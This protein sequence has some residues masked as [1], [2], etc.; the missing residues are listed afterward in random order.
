MVQ[1]VPI[2][3]HAGWKAAMARK[4]RK[5]GRGAGTGIPS[6]EGRLHEALEGAH[7]W[8]RRNKFKSSAKLVGRVRLMAMMGSDY[9]EGRYTRIPVTTIWVI[10]F[11]LLYVAW[12]FDII[13]DF[14]P[15]MG[16]LDDAFIIGLVFGA[17]SRDLRK[18]CKA[19]GLN[20]NLFGL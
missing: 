2:T 16:W 3:I 11:A 15:G 18:Y 4:R 6:R 17:I 1:A 20:P 10:T 9:L 12:P 8:L 14:I 5:S 7:R 13:P 19:T